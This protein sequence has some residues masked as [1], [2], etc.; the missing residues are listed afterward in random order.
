[1]MRRPPALIGAIGSALSLALCIDLLS[2][3]PTRDMA[4]PS[5][6][7]VGTASISGQ[8]VTDDSPGRPLRRVVVT[9][10][11]TAGA[12]VN[13]LALTDDAGRFVFPGLPPGRYVIT[14]RRPPFLT[15]AY[16]ARRIANVGSVQ[17]G[18][19]IAVA[20]DQHVRDT[21]IKLLRGSV[22]AVS[23]C[24][25]NGHA[26]SVFS[27]S[28]SYFQRS[29]TT[30]ERTLT[31]YYSDGTSAITDDRG[32]YRLYGLS[33]GEY[34]VCASAGYERAATDLITVPDA[35]IQRVFDVLQ[36]PGAAPIALGPAAVATTPARRPTME[37]APIHFPVLRPSIKQQR[38]SLVPAKNAQ[39]S[40][41]KHNS[42][43]RQ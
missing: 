37:Y 39:T 20:A 27:V 19:A 6:V 10:A 38:S 16:G 4:R 13:R 25:A 17:T 36:R 42:S 11:E 28:L 1:M 30:G 5:L 3:S 22:I 2:Q 34:V 23:I 14:A 31:Q 40:I 18:T 33:P 8:V 43:L 35:E 41:S 29:P 7:S 9:A 32:S 12:I 26:A 24:D 21:V 15:G